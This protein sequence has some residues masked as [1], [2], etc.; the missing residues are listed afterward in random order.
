MGFVAKTLGLGDGEKALIDLRWDET[1]CGRDNRGAGGRLDFRFASTLSL[2]PSDQILASTIVSG[3]PWNRGRIVRMK[4][5]AGVGEHRD[6][7]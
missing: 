1:G 5:D 3:R 4:T 2:I 6:R 7:R